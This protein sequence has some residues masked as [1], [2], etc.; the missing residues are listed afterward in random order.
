DFEERRKQ[1]ASR[2]LQFHDKYRLPSPFD[3]LPLARPTATIQRSTCGHGHKFHLPLVSVAGDRDSRFKELLGLTAFSFKCAGTV[4]DPFVQGRGQAIRYSLYWSSDP[5]LWQVDQVDNGLRCYSDCQPIVI[6]RW[7][8]AEAA[9][10]FD[11]RNLL[12][13]WGKSHAAPP[14]EC[15]RCLESLSDKLKRDAESGELHKEVLRPPSKEIKLLHG[16]PVQATTVC[17]V[18]DVSAI[19]WQMAWIERLT[20]LKGSNQFF[21]G[22]EQCSVEFQKALSKSLLLWPELMRRC[23]SLAE[24]LIWTLYGGGIGVAA[25]FAGP[26]PIPTYVSVKSTAAGAVNVAVGNSTGTVRK[27]VSGIVVGYDYGIGILLI[28]RD[29]VTLDAAMW[30]FIKDKGDSLYRLVQ[31]KRTDVPKSDQDCLDAVHQKSN[32]RSKRAVVSLGDVYCGRRFACDVREGEVMEI[33][34]LRLQAQSPQGQI[35]GDRRKQTEDLIFR[36]S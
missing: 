8:A 13:G 14:Q 23:L 36:K 22:D 19:C 4:D 26:L 27:G 28:P 5:S 20:S 10:A 6:K 34:S 32:V 33:S 21:G 29:R 3:F 18:S 15:F 11:L 12:S 35:P 1:A 17:A 25:K 2:I 9:K 31:F 24:M 30:Q 16:V 7:S